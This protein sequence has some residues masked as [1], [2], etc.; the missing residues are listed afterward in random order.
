M[1]GHKL[2]KIKSD[3]NDALKNL[4][5]DLDIAETL[6][7]KQT[8]GGDSDGDKQDEKWTPERWYQEIKKRWYFHEASWYMFSETEQYMK[9]CDHPPTTEVSMIDNLCFCTPVHG[10]IK[11]CYYYPEQGKL[12][13]SQI[14]K[15]IEG[16]NKFPGIQEAR[17]TLEEELKKLQ[18]ELEKSKKEQREGRKEKHPL[19]KVLEGKPFWIWHHRHLHLQQF[20]MTQGRCCFNHIIGEPQ[21]HSRLYPLF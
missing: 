12:E 14:Q 16:L 11:K 17:K 7:Q 13:Y 3:G 19:F 4:L 9:P 1:A 2:I 10:C 8:G 18:E 21:K 15:G 5:N 20:L 6:N